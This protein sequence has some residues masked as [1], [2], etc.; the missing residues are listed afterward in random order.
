[1]TEQSDVIEEAPHETVVRLPEPVRW[2]NNLP[3]FTMPDELKLDEFR[4]LVESHGFQIYYVYATVEREEIE[5]PKHSGGQPKR[6]V[7]TENALF[8]VTSN[9]VGYA[10]EEVTEVIPFAEVKP[11]ASYCLPKIPWSFV[12]R[13]DVFFREIYRVHNAESI[14]I[15]TFNPN[16]LDEQYCAENNVRAEDGWGLLVPDQT[17]NAAHCNYDPTSVV[18]IKPDD[19]KVVGSW[20]SH[21]AMSAF[22]SAT[23]HSDQQG[24]DGLHITTGWR[25]DVSEWYAEMQMG[26]S[27]YELHPS[28]IFCDIPLGTIEDYPEITEW[29]THVTKAAP[30]PP[31]VHYSTGNWESREGDRA[32]RLKKGFPDGEKFYGIMQWATRVLENETD[33]PVCDTRIS[34]YSRDS[35]KCVYCQTYMAFGE[36]TLNEMRAVRNAK[37]HGS[38]LL[39]DRDIDVSNLD[40]LSRSVVFWN[41]REIANPDGSFT[42]TGD[43]EFFIKPPKA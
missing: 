39:T 17:N 15:L 35:R 18:E 14:V 31:P 3:V 8:Q 28:Q 26:D 21:P 9:L 6:T 20:H 24:F 27:Q 5:A 1:M 30:P 43:L 29:M 36:E 12:Q 10:I 4:A 34:D 7:W 23:D 32:S 13:L 22:A 16:H 25:G 40:G 19:V 41:R 33:C 42:V 11:K 37:A 38:V 2:L